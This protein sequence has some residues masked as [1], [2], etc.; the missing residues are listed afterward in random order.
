[1]KK[2]TITLIMIIAAILLSTVLIYSQH[3]K[4]E[5]YKLI[6]QK[7]SNLYTM[8]AFLDGFRYKDMAKL[9]EKAAYKELEEFEAN[10]T[11]LRLSYA[12]LGKIFTTEETAQKIYYQLQ[13]SYED[14]GA[15]GEEWEAKIEIVEKT[16][17]AKLMEGVKKNVIYHQQNYLWMSRYTTT[18]KIITAWKGSWKGANEVSALVRWSKSIKDQKLKEKIILL[19]PFDDIDRYGLQKYLAHDQ[20]L[21]MAN[22]YFFGDIYLAYCFLEKANVSKTELRKFFNDNRKKMDGEDFF[23]FYEDSL[24][25]K[26]NLL[27]SL[28]G[29]KTDK[30]IIFTFDQCED[31]GIPYLEYLEI[32]ISSIKNQEDYFLVAE[33]IETTA[34]SSAEQS[35]HNL[36]YERKGSLLKK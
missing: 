13:D 28:K 5:R 9:A 4:K 27:K 20:V 31:W 35:L 21:K 1:M 33:F 18:E 7:N 19:L 10:P 8:S 16:L 25:T 2:Q 36:L 29:L 34:D 14:Y 6:K 24:I 15:Y 30:L 12:T 17:P 32:L 22:N 11:T 3:S 26:P 23:G